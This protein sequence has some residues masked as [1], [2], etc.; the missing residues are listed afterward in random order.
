[1]L[2]ISPHRVL[3]NNGMVKVA[4]GRVAPGAEEKEQP[5][6]NCNLP[7]LGGTTA[8]IESM[9]KLFAIQQR[10]RYE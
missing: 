4:G 2:F 7:Y 3:H 1:M 10:K 6:S 5:Q 8:L 9:S